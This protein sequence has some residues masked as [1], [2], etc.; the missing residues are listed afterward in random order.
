M[1]AGNRPTYIPGSRSVVQ[2]AE[3][4]K[5]A[6]TEEDIDPENAVLP[7]AMEWEELSG[8]AQSLNKAASEDDQLDGRHV[9]AVTLDKGGRIMVFTQKWRTAMGDVQVPQ[10]FEPEDKD[11][12]VR[13]KKDNHLHAEMLAISSYLQGHAKLPQYIGVSKPVCARCSAVLTF[14]KIPH[15]TDGDLTDSWISP[16]HHA[17][18]KPP[19]AL[20]GKIPKTVRKKRIFPYKEGE[21]E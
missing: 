17:K 21:W 16:W 10:I 1:L 4:R 19:V 12:V 6:F 13:N 5:F 3:E 14:F 18:Q 15:Y 11:Y 9:Q 2:R 20:K 8:I 7:E